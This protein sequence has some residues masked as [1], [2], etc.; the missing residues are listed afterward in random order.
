MELADAVRFEFQVEAADTP[1]VTVPQ[2]VVAGQLGPGPIIG[3]RIFCRKEIAGIWS[4]LTSPWR[5]KT[6]W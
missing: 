5:Q 1:E 3:G 6:A 4:Q 2:M